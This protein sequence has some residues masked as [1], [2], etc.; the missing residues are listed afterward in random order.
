MNPISRGIKNA[1]RSPVRTG[2]IILMLAVS[3]TLIVSMLVARAGINDK[4]NE[5]KQTAGTN[6]TIAPAG[7]RGF[8][9]GGNPLTADQV[10]TIKTTDHVSSI[11][12]TLS[13]QLGEDDTNLESALELGRFGQRQQR[14][15]ANTDDTD[16]TAPAPPSDDLDGEGTGRMM[17]RPRTTVTGTTDPDSVATDGSS[18]TLT[19]G[20]MIDA[21]GGSKVALVGK[22]LAE[23]NNLSVGSTFTMY[24]QTF[25]VKGIFSTDNQFQDSGLIIPLKTLQT[26]TDQADAVTSVV[27]TVDSS[28]NVATVVTSLKSSLGDKADITSQVE[29]A[30]QSVASLESIAGLALGGVIGAAGAGAIIILLAMIMIVRERRREIGVIK[31]IGGTNRSVI[32]QFMSEALTLTIIGGIVGLA[33]GVAVSG[34]M[35]SGLV[36]SN[37]SSTSTQGRDGS[38]RMERGGSP[39]RPGSFGAPGAQIS[40]TVNDINST[41]TPQAF[42]SALGIMFLIA[43]IGS[44]VPAWI[45]ANIKPAE[46][47][48]SE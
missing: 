7:I 26:L 2:A 10:A 14:F 31:A 33:I 15:N 25:T 35:T 4:I 47:L 5:V 40:Q 16:Q 43:I 29:Q 37:S 23:K 17:M 20:E 44:A 42:A 6:V 27:A 38:D 48:R 13:D 8:M 21:S 11:T 18:L 45:I 34:P 39:N 19:S 28:D 12:S 3:I 1:L 36:A 32:T 41:V 22:T 46:V 24:E 9:G 30:E